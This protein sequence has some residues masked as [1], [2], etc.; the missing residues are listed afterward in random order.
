MRYLLHLRL[1]AALT[2]PLAALLLVAPAHAAPTIEVHVL[3]ACGPIT[4]SG[5]YT[6]AADLHIDGEDCFT[7]AVPDVTLDLGGATIDGNGTPGTAGIRVLPAA[8]NAQVQHGT[9]SH[10]DTGVEINAGEATVTRLTLQNNGTGIALNQA[11]G[12]EIERNVIS[13]SAS[14]AVAVQNSGRISITNN[15]IDGSGVYGVWLQGATHSLVAGNIIDGSG[16]TGVYLGCSANG[17]GGALDC[18]PSLDN[19]IGRN[20]VTGS[21]AFNIALDS[22]NTQNMLLENATSGAGSMDLLDG[23]DGCA[24]NRWLFNTFTMISQA[25]TQ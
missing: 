4:A 21:G 18:Q 13:Q 16:N 5:Y 23:N 1:P 3:E 8:D 15:R 2:A 25:C 7:I 17:A 14:Y 24:G 19:L 22:G 10:F 20:T 11:D 9:V 12:G 6:V